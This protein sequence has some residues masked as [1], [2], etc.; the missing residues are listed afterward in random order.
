MKLNRSN[1][2]SPCLRCCIV[3][4]GL[5]SPP[6]HNSVVLSSAYF[7][8]EEK[9]RSKKVLRWSGT[10]PGCPT[11]VTLLEPRSNTLWSAVYYQTLGEIVFVISILSKQIAHSGEHQFWDRNRKVSLLVGWLVGWL[12]GWLFYPLMGST[13]A[14]SSIV[15]HIVT[16]LCQGKEL[17]QGWGPDGICSSPFEDSVLKYNLVALLESPLTICCLQPPPF[18]LAAQQTQGHSLSWSLEVCFPPSLPLSTLP[19]SFLQ[20]E[21]PFWSVVLYDLLIKENLG[22]L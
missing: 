19:V 6:N 7:L 12:A 13:W 16:V 5:V 11:D 18:C 10:I 22:P 21:V 8:L 14:L 15:N 2:W 9:S 20:A 17:G 1:S 3:G 4:K